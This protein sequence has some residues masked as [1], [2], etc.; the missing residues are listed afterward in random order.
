M[1]SVVETNIVP[2]KQYHKD[3][4]N[5]QTSKLYLESYFLHQEKM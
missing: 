2:L 1:K 4:Y 3:C 5:F